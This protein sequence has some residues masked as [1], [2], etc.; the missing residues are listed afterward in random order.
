MIRV[1]ALISIFLLAG[2]TT[3]GPAATS[4]AVA[5]TGSVSLSLADLPDTPD[6]VQD[7]FSSAFAI[8]ASAHGIQFDPGAGGTVIA[9]G[10]LSVA[11]SASGTLLIYVFDFEDGNGNRLTRIGGQTSSEAASPDPWD[12]IDSTLVDGV[13]THV[14]DEFRRWLDD[15]RV[16]A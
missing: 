10:Y 6:R 4:A 5:N 15:N 9:R 14:L 3:T 7:A 11:G 12:A 8:E 16:S 2:C 13:V 1:L